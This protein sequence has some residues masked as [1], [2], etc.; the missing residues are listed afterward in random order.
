MLL[1]LPTL[2]VAQAQCT[3]YQAQKDLQYQVGP[4]PLEPSI[5]AATAD[6]GAILAQIP[7]LQA[8]GFTI[9][10]Y[11]FDGCTGDGIHALINCHASWGGYGVFNG[12]PQGA[13]PPHWDDSD[14]IAL[15]TGPC[16]TQKYWLTAA[17][18]PQG[19]TCSANCVGDPINPGPGNVYKREEED[20]RVGGASPLAFQRFYD[21]ADK[22]GAD[23]APGWRHSYGRS[24]ATNIQ[25]IQVGAYPGQSATVSAQYD[26]A[27]AA[28]A[29]GFA[30]I[31]ASVGAW[32]GAV[33]AYIN[34]VCVISN[35]GATIGTLTVNSPYPDPPVSP[36]EEYDIVRDDGQTFRFTT[37]GGSVNNPPGVSLRLAVTG[38][39][40]TVTDDQDN[41]E[42]YNSS[43]ILQSI[44]TRAGIVQSLSYDSNGLLS[45]VT[46]SFGNHLTISRN[47]PRQ[48]VG[49]SVNG[50]TAVKFAYDSAYRLATITNSDAVTSRDK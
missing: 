40:F 20:V 4:G 9:Y 43:G 27:F 18:R 42:V 23:M 10:G 44:T 31:Q 5:A 47:T 19:E 11:V 46:D 13:T 29:V 22:T 8:P 17:T 41:V 45:G 37:Q 2:A 34:N 39:G 33:A 49:V 26:T 48:L 38:S 32:V 6:A 36:P 50:S 25:P 16:L 28:C 15:L 3:L 30:D 1:V 21:S 14:R 12:I 7:P 24:I 35:G